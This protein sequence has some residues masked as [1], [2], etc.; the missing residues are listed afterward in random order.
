[1]R[2]AVGSSGRARRSARTP[3]TRDL[4]NN[5]TA[6]DEASSSTRSFETAHDEKIVS[7]LQEKNIQ[8]LEV[9]ESTSTRP[10]LAQSPDG[11]QSPLV[12]PAPNR[13]TPKAT[14]PRLAVASS[15]PHR[16][17]P[18][19]RRHARDASEAIANATTP[20][21]ATAAPAAA[22]PI[23]R[24]CASPTPRYRRTTSPPRPS[25][26]RQHPRRST[27]TGFKARI[28]RFP[29]LFPFARPV[30]PARSAILPSLRRPPPDFTPSRARARP[31]R[32]RRRRRRTPPRFASRRPSRSRR[33][34]PSRRRAAATHPP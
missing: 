17:R 5:R 10:S 33:R 20:A 12:H 21:A 8:S 22:G 4:S 15:P 14:R 9:D 24:T 2:G 1:M 34:R 11:R 3:S 27:P 16:H 23:P 30:R 32:R 7:G 28:D 25:R 19:R 26:T 13:P 18:R 29:T 6:A 31:R